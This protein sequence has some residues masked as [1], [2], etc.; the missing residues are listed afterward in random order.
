MAED[1]ILVVDDE[2]D[3]TKMISARLKKAGYNVHSVLSGKEAIDYVKTNRPDLILLDVLM[4]NMDGYQA[5]KKLKE[6]ESTKSIPVI[7]LTAKGQVEDVTRA[8]NLGAFDYIVKPFSPVT[9]LEK[10]H[11]ALE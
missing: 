3:V 10:I 6:E 5:L 7:M 11:K 9:L 2:V 8:A 4:P 1:N